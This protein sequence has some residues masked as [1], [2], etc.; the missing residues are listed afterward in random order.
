MDS[1]SAVQAFFGTQ[2]K[3][4][5]DIIQFVKQIKKR[6]PKNLDSIV[7]DLHDQTFDSIDCLDCANCCKSISP[8]VKDV[9][10]ERL[11]KFLKVKPSELV[12]E[13]FVIDSDGDYVFKNQPCPFLMPDNYCLVYEARPKACRE[14]PHTDR[15][16]FAQLL[17]LSQ[18]NMEICPAVYSIMNELKNTL[19]NG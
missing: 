10:I 8:G 9:D 2:Q 3:I 16:R 18:K 11:S 17:Q 13:H 12:S 6:A 1:L 19:N 4:S 15:R 5:K 7:H 14:Y